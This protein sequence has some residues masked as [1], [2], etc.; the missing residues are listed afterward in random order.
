VFLVSDFLD[1]GFEKSL[2]VL[3]RRH[4][5]IAV[6]VSDPREE[7]LP[8]VGLLEIEDAESGATALVDTGSAAVRRRYETLARKRGEELASLFRAAG[9][10]HIRLSTDR[11]YLLDLVR[12]FRGRMK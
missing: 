4:D 9:V 10:D 8:D 5:L 6:T 1:R 12:F 3:A 11:D 7:G 2:R